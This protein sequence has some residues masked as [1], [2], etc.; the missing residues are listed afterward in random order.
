MISHQRLKPPALVLVAGWSRLAA[1]NWGQA[2]SVQAGLEEAGEP[3]VV[4]EPAQIGAQRAHAVQRLAADEEGRL[5]DVVVR[6]VEALGHAI[7]G[8]QIRREDVA[9][10]IDFQRVTIH[11]VGRRLLVERGEGGGQRPR[12][13]DIVRIQPADDAAAGEPPAF[14]DG[15]C[16]TC[17][18]FAPPG[19]PAGVTRHHLS[20]AVLRPGIE[21]DQLAAAVELLIKHTAHGL[22]D[23]ATVVARWHQNGEI[24]H[25]GGHGQARRAEVRSS[26]AAAACSRGSNWVRGRRDLGSMKRRRYQCFQ[27]W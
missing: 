12:Q 8:E 21:H 10:G 6:G 5:A 4:E 20:G 2:P 26:R 19:E 11:E 16:L 13:V 14:V 3:L 7:L 18:R 27:G 23:P 25:G 22:L 1:R 17:V 9:P 24:R 15:V